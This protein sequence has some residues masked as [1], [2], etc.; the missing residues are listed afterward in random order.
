MNNTCLKDMDFN[1]G[2]YIR[3]SQE[4]KDKKYE[5]DSESV[6]NQ[7]ELLRSYVKNLKFNLV[8]EYVD[9]GYSGTDFDRPGFKKLLQDIE[10]NKINCVIV[11]DLSRLGRDHVMTGYYMETF[12]PEKNIRFI[13]ILESFDSF[14]NQASNDSSTFIIAC[15][16]YYSK[17]NS[18]KI[19]NVLNDKRKNGKFIGSKPSYGYMRDPLDKGHLIVDP[20]TGP[21]VKRI[22]ELRV[23][24]VGPTDICS[25]L[26]DE[27]IA[28]PSGYKNIKHSSRL[29]VN[30]EWTTSS[31]KKILTNQIYTGDMIQHTQTKVNYKSKKK[32]TLDRSQWDI[33]EN[34]HEALVDKETFNYAQVLRTRYSKNMKIKTNREKRLFEG[35]IY[36]KEC[37][38]RLSIYLRK[39]TG[40][41]SINC[42]QYSRDPRRGRCSSH[43][44]PYD[45][46]EEQLLKKFNDKVSGL[47]KELDIEELNENVKKTLAKTTKT[48]ESKLDKLTKDKEILLNRISKLYDDRCNG[49]ISVEIYKELASGDEAKLK[50]VNQRIEE[51]NFKIK[52][53]QSKESVMI[54]YTKKII[55]LLDLKKPK[56]ELINSLVDRIVIDKDRN[57]TMSFK[58]DILEEI[59]FTYENVNKARNPYGRKGKKSK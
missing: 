41:W 3:L 50:E 48:V 10:S 59:N 32:I 53:M 15:N 35:L 27:H 46:L 6:I 9:D 47:M 11:K 22:F 18:I 33:V 29:K 31:I 51:E 21:I 54:D 13:S 14:K 20:E 8:D 16:D 56:I 17:Q 36:C 44:F 30:D 40:Y 25:I 57:I 12:F 43:F 42:N 2:I 52:H 37:G 45:F 49:T 5:S 28:T 19:R 24:G 39:E 26:N 55:E 34:T 23:S 1:V 7:R 58:F 4:D 38:N